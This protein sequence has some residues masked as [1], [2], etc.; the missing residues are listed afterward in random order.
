MNCGMVLYRDNFLMRVVDVR[1]L[2]KTE[3]KGS[4][5]FWQERSFKSDREGEI[6]YPLY[7]ESKKK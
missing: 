1:R 6:S 4:E 2:R 7:V 3:S 5:I